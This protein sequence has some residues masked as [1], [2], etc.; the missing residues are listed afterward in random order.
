MAFAVV[1]RPSAAI[2]LR[3]ARQVTRQRASVVVRAADSTIV[4]VNSIRKDEPKVVD[5]ISSDDIKGKVNF[6][7]TIGTDSPPSLLYE[8]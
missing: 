3:S 6:L 8:S 7:Q 2:Q 5:M 1:S 4:N